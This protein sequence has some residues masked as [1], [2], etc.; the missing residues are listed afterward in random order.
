M[1]FT[2]QQINKRQRNDN[3]IDFNNFMSNGFIPSSSTNFSTTN[4][5]Y[6]KTIKINLFRTQCVLLTFELFC[7]LFLFLLTITSASLR[8]S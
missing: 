4:R 1:N 3:N 2:K 5:N 6:D 8:P 7:A